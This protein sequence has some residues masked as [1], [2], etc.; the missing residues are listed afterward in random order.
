MAV[1]DHQGLKKQCCLSLSDEEMKIQ[2]ARRISTAILTLH[3]HIP[4]ERSSSY[5]THRTHLYTHHNMYVSIAMIF[6]YILFTTYVWCHSYCCICCRPPTS[7]MMGETSNHLS[8]NEQ[9]TL[10]EYT[11]K[12]IEINL[13]SVMVIGTKPQPIVV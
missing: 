12:G 3:A 13:L 7:K 6:F 10:E 5:H 8:E 1:R 11:Y 4:Q 2:P 9:Q